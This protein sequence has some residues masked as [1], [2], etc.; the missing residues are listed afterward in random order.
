MITLRRA[1]ERHHELY[2]QGQSWLSFHP[3]TRTLPFADGFGILEGFNETKLLPSVD[4]PLQARPEADVVTYVRGGSL[5][6]EDSLGR[7]GVIQAGEFQ[8]MTAGRRIHHT[9]ANA[10]RTEEVHFFQIC[11]RSSETQVPQVQEQK[12]FSVA[13]R[14]GLLCPVA[15]P[16]GRDGSLSIRPDALILSG[17]LQRGHHVVHPLTQGR[18]AW[19][20]LIEGEGTL[21]EVIL[22]AGDSAGLTSRHAVSFTARETT[23]VLLLDLGDHRPASSTKFP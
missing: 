4:A 12:R 20:H 16:D 13:Q 14:R 23:E 8:C 9:E 15:S 11:L 5:A 22:N 10:S 21:E 18:S 7:S 19:L 3:Q 1:N 6:F 17:L 2:R